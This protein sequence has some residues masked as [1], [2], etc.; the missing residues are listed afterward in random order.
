MG[1]STAAGEV[2]WPAIS[3][4]QAK[5]TSFRGSTAMGDADPQASVL[6]KLLG[7]PIDQVQFGLTIFGKR[8]PT[9][10]WIG[11]APVTG[12]VLPCCR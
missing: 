11:R 5:I 8:K 1:P 7:L 10:A 6:A 2:S 12:A 4:R 9:P 3:M